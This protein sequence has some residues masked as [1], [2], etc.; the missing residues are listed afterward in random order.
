[1]AHKI[2]EKAPKQAHK[3]VWHNKTGHSFVENRTLKRQIGT[4]YAN[5]A[6]KCAI[7]IYQVDGLTGFYLC[8]CLI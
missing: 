7:L 4:F 1:M 8:V 2:D 5:F 3:S 6:V